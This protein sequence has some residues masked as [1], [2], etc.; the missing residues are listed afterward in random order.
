MPDLLQ[1]IRDSRDSKILSSLVRALLYFGRYF[2][3]AEV[4]YADELVLHFGTPIAY[5]NPLL[6]DE[7]RGQFLLGTRGSKWTIA[8]RDPPF[9]I[10]SGESGVDV[11]EKSRKLAGV[12]VLEVYTAD[13][14]V[15]GQ[16][17]AGEVLVIRLADGTHIEIFPAEDPEKT[18]LAD[19]EL[20]TPFG[21]YLTCGPGQSWSWLPSRQP[22]KK[23]ETPSLG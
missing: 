7:S 18:H 16:P 5:E 2:N 22:I 21:M 11:E 14:P 6:A 8:M 12:Q 19:W 13:T 1:E 4:S 15:P 20:F 17:E 3:K 23:N 10:S 9:T